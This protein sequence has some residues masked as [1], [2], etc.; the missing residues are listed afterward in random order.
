MEIFDALKVFFTK[1]G[2]LDN[3]WSPYM[4]SRFLSMDSKFRSVSFL[5]NNYVYYVNADIM[6]GLFFFYL[7]RYDRAPYIRY[8]KSMKE[9]ESEYQGIFMA[10]QNYYQW[11]DAELNGY[12]S[13]YVNLFEDKEQLEAYKNFIGGASDEIKKRKKKISNTKSKR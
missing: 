3:S 9:K 8:M 7:P 2:A 12:K 13:F 10:L 5:A 6:K 11:T 1:K 4:V